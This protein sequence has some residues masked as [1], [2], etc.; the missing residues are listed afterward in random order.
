M[1]DDEGPARP[2]GKTNVGLF[3]AA[4]LHRAA[5]HAKEKVK[6]GAIERL[7]A[8]TNVLVAIR[9]RPPNRGEDVCTFAEEAED[10]ITV[11]LK[12]RSSSMS[13]GGPGLAGRARRM[14]F[15]EQSGGEDEDDEDD[16][17]RQRFDLVCG[18]KTTQRKA[19]ALMGRRILLK[20]IE[21]FNG[22]VFAYGQTGSGKTHTMIG[23]PN[24]VGMIPRLCEELFVELAKEQHHTSFKLQASYI[25][26]YKDTIVDLLHN[27]IV[28]GASSSG[29][30]HFAT[31]PR[32]SPR[33]SGA[34]HPV[35]GH[36]KSMYPGGGGGGG[37]GGGSSSGSMSSPPAVLLQRGHSGMLHHHHGD[38]SSGPSIH[39]DP[40]KGIVVLGVEKRIV[41]SYKDIQALLALG[42][43]RKQVAATA[44]NSRSSRSHTVFSLQLKQRDLKGRDDD[45]R[46]TKS[47]KLHLIDLAGSE[48]VGRSKTSGERLAEGRQINLSLSALSNV[49]HALTEH[50][51]ARAE[52]GGNGGGGTAGGAVEGFGSSSSSSS[53]SSSGGAGGFESRMAAHIPYRDSKLTRLLQDSLGGNAQTLMICTVSPAAC[54]RDETLC[55]LRFA[56]RA[57]L[58]ENRCYVNTDSRNERVAALQRQLEDLKRQ[59]GAALEAAERGDPR[60]LEAAEADFEVQLAAERAGRDQAAAD[61]RQAVQEK[62]QADHD[63]QALSTALETTLAKVGTLKDDMQREQAQVEARAAAAEAEASAAEGRAAEAAARAT[64]AEGDLAALTQLQK[65]AEASIEAMQV[66]AIEERR[67]AEDAAAARIAAAEDRAAEAEARALAAEGRASEAERAGKEARVAAVKKQAE[68]QEQAELIEK[69]QQEQQRDEE[70]KKRVAA[71]RAAAAGSPGSGGSG[72]GRQQGGMRYA[73][74]KRSIDPLETARKQSMMRMRR[75]LVG[76]R[77]AVIHDAVGKASA[78]ERRLSRIIAGGS[79]AEEKSGSAGNMSGIGGGGGGGSGGG[80][81]TGGSG[82]SSPLMVGSVSPV[83]GNS[84]VVVPPPGSLSPATRGRVGGGSGRKESRDTGGGA[85]GGG[86][87]RRISFNGGTDGG[88]KPAASHPQQKEQSTVAST[89]NNSNGDDNEKVEAKKGEAATSSSE[90]RAE[91][92]GIAAVLAAPSAGASGETDEVEAPPPAAKEVAQAKEEEK[93]G[94]SK[95]PGADLGV[96]TVAAADGE[97]NTPPA[98]PGDIATTT[99]TTTTT[100]TVGEPASKEAK[101]RDSAKKIEAW[102]RAAKEEKAKAIVEAGGSGATATATATGAGSP[103]SATQRKDS[104]TQKIEAIEAANR[105]A[106]AAV[107]AATAASTSAQSVPATIKEEDAREEGGQESQQHYNED[108][109]ET[110]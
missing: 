110:W 34:L 68:K 28:G 64:K 82:G 62:E 97:A 63:V 19:Y 50:A 16:V 59:L 46:L 78:N 84:V 69:L 57:K 36:S 58:V 43:Q 5:M 6:V 86:S 52:R 102:G 75:D 48:R 107:A 18:P 14:S 95:T 32:G 93:D 9:V 71:E 31:S 24:N 87:A 51:A 85:G 13:R 98:G 105:A 61:A 108:P 56:A 79:A 83:W 38:G 10:T 72:G 47:S 21:G 94:A 89:S 11:N 42:A 22:C 26:I 70:E 40:R 39:E 103:G 45:F 54:N 33:S 4:Q 55:S 17:K 109:N 66:R 29:A 8:K 81:G 90:D 65:Q 2:R 15:G 53:S 30:S 76:A 92:G 80:G 67:A 37:G 25:E 73:R 60:Q 44:L 35:L 106:K 20:F 12:D 27:P 104:L 1:A 88:S 77:E 101:R 91:I 23:E 96:G 49:I 3:A 7:V 74:F 100:T 41:T 99:T